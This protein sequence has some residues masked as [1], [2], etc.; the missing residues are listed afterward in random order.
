MN[1]YTIPLIC[2]LSRHHQS[3]IFTRLTFFT[4]R[5][6]FLSLPLILQ[7]GLHQSLNHF[8]QKKFF[9]E[10]L[11]NFFA[12]VVLIRKKEKQRDQLDNVSQKLSLNLI[13][14]NL[15][16]FLISNNLGRNWSR[17]GKGVPRQVWTWHLIAIYVR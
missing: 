7:L 10:S 3:N 17:Q 14:S 16:A 6:L 13:S 4:F 15:T 2:S 11:E 1:Y 5:F 12:F 9:F 8:W